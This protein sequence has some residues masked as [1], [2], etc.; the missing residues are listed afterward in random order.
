MEFFSM[1]L[2]TLLV[3]LL[4]PSFAVAAT[5]APVEK[6]ALRAK[7]MEETRLIAIM[8]LDRSSVTFKDDGDPTTL[9]VVFLSKRS[10]GPSRVSA[11]GEIVFLYKAS[12]HLQ[13][14]LIDR[15]FDL[16]VAREIGGR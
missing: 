15:A 8:D 3:A 10:D 1:R 13:S 6:A 5:D 4:F 12:D 16:R 7:I 2:E 9:E 11:D 14:E